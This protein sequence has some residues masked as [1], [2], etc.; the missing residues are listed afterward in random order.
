MRKDLGIALKA[1]KCVENL[2]SSKDDDDEEDKFEDVEHLIKRFCKFL[3]KERCAKEANK[4]KSKL[5]CYECHKLSHARP[6][7]PHLKKH[8][9]RTKK[10][11]LDDDSSYSSDDE[12][13][14][15]CFTAHAN[16]VPFP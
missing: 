9:K 6:D 12:V 5:I 14:A 7:C 2:S 10:R 1:S 11:S 3:S 16:V 8:S 13:G 15:V 4:N